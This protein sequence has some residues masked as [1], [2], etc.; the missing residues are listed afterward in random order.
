MA[1]LKTYLKELESAGQTERSVLDRSVTRLQQ[2]GFDLEEPPMEGKRA[3]IPRIPPQGI[4]ALTDREIRDLHGEF[5]TI[6]A[7][8]EEQARIQKIMAEEYENEANHVQT[9]VK[10]SLE[11]PVNVREDKAK[12]HKKVLALKKRCN[13]CNATYHLLMIKVEKFERARG[14]CSRDVEFRIR[15]I[16]GER[17]DNAIGSIKGKRRRA[18]RHDEELGDL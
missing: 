18:R 14:A 4:S 8:A 6:K 11:G 13:E 2:M 10:L 7:Y 1:N 16:D 15:E 17:R 12:V 9:T 5:I 3:H